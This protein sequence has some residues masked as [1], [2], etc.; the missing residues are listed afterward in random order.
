M[1]AVLIFLVAVLLA[2]CLAETPPLT[3]EQLANAT[4]ATRNHTNG[5]VTLHDGEFIDVM[6][7]VRID[8]PRRLVATGDLDG[9]GVPD[10]AV[11]L[12]A[13]TGGSGTFET[14]N[15]VL[16]KKGRP[17]HAAIGFL[18][19]RVKINSIAI[20]EGE[21]EVDMVVH[22]PADPMCCPTQEEVRRFSLG[23]ET[24]K[25]VNPA[26][27]ERPAQSAPSPDVKSES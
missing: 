1:R 12:A 13:N 16:N 3:W 7:R 15:V 5:A 23:N 26:M 20:V 24:M 21:I 18:G 11:I 9:D 25:P 6:Q 8:L 14:V 2:G 19:D 22:A 27:L 4:Y 10:A 17:Q